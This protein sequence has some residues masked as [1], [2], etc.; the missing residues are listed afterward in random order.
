M[1]DILY[2]CIHVR[3]T[4]VQRDHVTWFCKSSQFLLLSFFHKMISAVLDV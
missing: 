2:I 3:F 4:S 1:L